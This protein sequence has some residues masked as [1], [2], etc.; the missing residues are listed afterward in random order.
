MRDFYFDVSTPFINASEHLDT[1]LLLKCAWVSVMNSFLVV[2][3]QFTA[4]VRFCTL[5]RVRAYH[6]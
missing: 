5:I 4:S 6:I 1:H 3:F 2:Y